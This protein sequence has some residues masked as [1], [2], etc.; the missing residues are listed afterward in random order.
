MPYSTGDCGKFFPLSF[1]LSLCTKPDFFVCISTAGEGLCGTCLVAMEKGAELLNPC[2]GVEEMITRGRPLSWR[3]SCR[4]VV[5]FNN[6]GGTVR[7]RV[8]PQTQF[9]DEINPGVKSINRN[10]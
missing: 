1:I 4:A 9:E 6:E 10:D 8:Q 2:L 7:L 5:G 3:A